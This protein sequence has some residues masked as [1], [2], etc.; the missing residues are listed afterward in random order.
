MTD[1]LIILLSLTSLGSVGGALRWFLKW[2][3]PPLPAGVRW[4]LTA[5]GYE[6]RR[7]EEVLAIVFMQRDR[8]YSSVVG[9]DVSG[10]AQ[11]DSAPAPMMRATVRALAAAGWVEREVTP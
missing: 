4:V 9:A 3:N 5:K 8:W 1:S 10:Y 7:V 11:G 6:L 2:R